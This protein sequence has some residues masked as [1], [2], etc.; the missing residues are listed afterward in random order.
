MHHGAGLG[1][2]VIEHIRGINPHMAIAQAFGRAFIHDHF[3]W[4]TV[5]HQAISI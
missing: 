4:E 5:C 3:S 1:A 2:C